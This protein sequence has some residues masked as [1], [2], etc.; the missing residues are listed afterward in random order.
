MR[1]NRIR[2]FLEVLLLAIVAS[3]RIGALV[4]HDVDEGH[5]N[6]LES[7]RWKPVSSSKRRA[8]LGDGAVKP[9]FDFFRQAR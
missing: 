6:L 5:I 3:D 4:H 8:N 1:K 2:E 9:A 7:G